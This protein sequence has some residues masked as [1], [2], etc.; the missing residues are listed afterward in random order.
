MIFLLCILGKMIELK[1]IQQT[2]TYIDS[3]NL[4]VV[5][6]NVASNYEMDSRIKKE[7]VGGKQ[8]LILF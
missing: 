8:S 4:I 1:R 6:Q 3:R 7:F 2:Q 5:A